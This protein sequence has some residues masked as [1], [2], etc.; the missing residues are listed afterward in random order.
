L[1]RYDDYELT[2]EQGKYWS[3][4]GRTGNKL[5]WDALKGVTHL[6]HQDVGDL[7]LI[8]VPLD[9]PNTGGG[10]NRTYHAP[11]KSTSARALDTAEKRDL[12]GQCIRQRGFTTAERVVEDVKIDGAYLA[13]V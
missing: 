10:H 12:P 7:Y 2:P 9:L 8:R 1:S 11:A 4:Q 3:R 13:F 5:R 6:R